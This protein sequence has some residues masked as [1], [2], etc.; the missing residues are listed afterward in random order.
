MRSV[1]GMSI[2]AMAG[3]LLPAAFA[4]AGPPKPPKPAPA[5]PAP[6]A[7]K[8]GPAGGTTTTSIATSVPGTEDLSSTGA[9]IDLS[10]VLSGK[11]TSG[12]ESSAPYLTSTIT[13]GTFNG[14]SGVFLTLSAPGLGFAGSADYE[15]VNNKD[16]ATPAWLF[17]LSSTS[18]LS[19]SSFSIVSTST[20][21]AS[22]RGSNGFTTPSITIGGSLK[23]SNSDTYNLGFGFD[24]GH[25]GSPPDGPGG[26]AEFGFGDSVTY[27]ISGLSRSSFI[28]AVSSGG[29]SSKFT[30]A[31]AIDDS[32]SNLWVAGTAVPVPAPIYGAGALVLGVLAMKLRRPVAV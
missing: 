22:Q 30:S 1:L 21:P 23:A 28:P 10:T 15:H 2:A 12:D 25:G 20:L 24:E 16:L 32:G 26:Q 9:S 6:K 19:Q 11:F 29:G 14:A 13:D 8:G 17:N 3:V 27:F 7:P 4:A 18:G 31:A 5:P